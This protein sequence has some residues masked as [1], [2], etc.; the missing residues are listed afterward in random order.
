MAKAVDRQRL[1][2]QMRK[3][4]RSYR[5][6][7]EFLDVSQVTIMRDVQAIEKRIGVPLTDYVRGADDRYYQPKTTVQDYEVEASYDEAEEEEPPL[8]AEGHLVNAL[9]SLQQALDALK[10][11]GAR[12]QQVPDLLAEIREAAKQVLATNK[13]LHP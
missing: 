13:S 2:E 12:D 7:A 6:I 3:D 4:G 11:N 9:S 5:S 8:S 10:A 1:V